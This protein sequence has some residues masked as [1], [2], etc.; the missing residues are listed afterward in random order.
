MSSQPK[1]LADWALK[2]SAK[3]RAWLADR[4]IAP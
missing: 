4:L 3:E 2:F 1:I